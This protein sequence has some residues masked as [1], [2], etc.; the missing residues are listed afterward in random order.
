MQSAVFQTL[1]QAL[2]EPQPLC[3]PLQLIYTLLNVVRL[4]HVVDL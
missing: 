1:Q 4:S 2:G 3:L